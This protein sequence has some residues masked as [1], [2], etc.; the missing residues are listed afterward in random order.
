MSFLYPFVLFALAALAIPIIVHLFSFRRYKT[1]YFS[2]VKFLEQVKFQH[3]SKN[4]LKHWLILLLRCLAFAALVFAFAG[5]VSKNKTEGSAASASGVYSFFIDNSLSMS[6]ESAEGQR[7]ELAR[8]Y[9]RRLIRQLP[10]DA[11][12][13]II[14]SNLES[15][16]RFSMAPEE[17]ITQL[18]ELEL[19]LNSPQLDAILPQI[20]SF[21]LENVPNTGG[22]SFILSDFQTHQFNFSKLSADSLNIFRLV[23]VTPVLQNNVSVDSAYMEAPFLKDNEIYPLKVRFTNHGESVKE[24][25]PV[26]VNMGKEQVGINSININPFQSADSAFFITTPSVGFNQYTIQLEDGA[27]A[28]DNTFYVSAQVGSAVKITEV[29]SQNAANVFS[30]LFSAEPYFDF[31]RIAENSVNRSLLAESDLLILNGVQSNDAFLNSFLPDYVEKGGNLLVI[32]EDADDAGFKNLLSLFALRTSAFNFQKTRGVEIE[33][34][35]PLF[36]DLFEKVPENINLPASQ[37]YYGVQGNFR[38]VITLEQQQPLLGELK[39]GKG[40]LFFYTIPADAQISNLFKH[41]IFA[42]TTLKLAEISSTKIPLFFTPNSNFSIPL[43]AEFNE[44]QIELTHE[45]S[46]KKTLVPV[47]IIA[48]KKQIFP[49]KYLE[50]PGFYTFLTSDLKTVTLAFNRNSKESEDSY[51]KASE[52]AERMEKAGIANVLPVSLAT[53][54]NANLTDLVSGNKPLWRYF[55]ALAI[56]FFLAEMILYRRENA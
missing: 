35:H 51:L 20:Q 52:L 2:Q 34:Q 18:E 39:R 32:P 22:V 7:F 31:N 16:A 11:K 17:A 3:A 38:N 26:S 12:V 56:L 5:P 8:T 50:T 9:A 49:G 23:E 41:G 24:D 30:I 13:Q 19:T 53:T 28:F 14:S 37:G 42:G 47:E 27:L 29:Y 43:A 4:N 21:L 33:K 40:S 36:L 46:G 45:E 10:P 55:I 6:G 44:G 54:Q 48:N 1:L 15:Y 25:I